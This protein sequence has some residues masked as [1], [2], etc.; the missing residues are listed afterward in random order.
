MCVH[1]RVRS[2][3][4]KRQG[5]GIV[6]SYAL[7]AGCLIGFYVVFRFRQKKLEGRAWVYPA[8][9]AT[10]PAYYWIFALYAGDSGVLL[11]EVATGAVFIALSY[12]AYRAR[13]VAGTVLLSAGYIAHACY[14]VAHDWLFL[15]PGTPRW[16]PEFCGAADLLIG[17][18]LVY[19]A[20]LL[21]QRRV[22][23]Y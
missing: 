19:Y 1:V 2:R 8:F 4:V 23:I 18:Y 10:F 5:T 22:K 14:D 7:L 6:N 11:N 17:F 9:L 12:A 15:N 16:W 3:D 21:R 20:V 13:S